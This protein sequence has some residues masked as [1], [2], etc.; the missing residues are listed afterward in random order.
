MLTTTRV[1]ETLRPNRR[2]EEVSAVLLPFCADGAIDPD[3]F[4]AYVHGKPG[5]AMAQYRRQ[6]DEIQSFGG[7]QIVFQSDHIKQLDAAE[8][9]DF[10]REIGRMGPVGRWCNITAATHKWAR[11]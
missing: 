1:R 4:G 7:T 11:W 5:D 3:G 2:I 10:Y 6:I 8:V 9:V